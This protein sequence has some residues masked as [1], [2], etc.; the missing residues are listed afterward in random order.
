MIAG[1]LFTRDF[2]TEGILSTPHWQAL[3]D[4][5]VADIHA[6]AATLFAKL[7]EIRSPSERV[8]EKDLIYPLLAAI[9]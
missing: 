5:V 9:G 3:D 8:T 6:K 4:H 7:T 1:G 2:L